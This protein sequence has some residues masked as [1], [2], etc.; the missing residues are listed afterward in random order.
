MIYFR[1]ISPDKTN[2][3]ILASTI[4]KKQILLTPEMV[5]IYSTLLLEIKKRSQ[6]GS[7]NLDTI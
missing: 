4:I 6:H 3:V 2:K 1:T 5:S 7:Q